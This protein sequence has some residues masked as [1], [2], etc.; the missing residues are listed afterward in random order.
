MACLTLLQD[1]LL[2]LTSHTTS[3]LECFSP[4]PL[5]TP[6]LCWNVLSHFGSHLLLAGYIPVISLVSN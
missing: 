3:V 6:L 5:F 2:K 1:S 4:F